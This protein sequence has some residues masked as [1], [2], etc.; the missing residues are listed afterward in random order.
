[1]VSLITRMGSVL[2]VREKTPRPVFTVFELAQRGDE[3]ALQLVDISDE[4][5]ETD[6]HGQT[7]LHVASYEG[8]FLLVKALIKRGANIEACDKN[9]YTPLHSAASNGDRTVNHL[10]V[11]S[12]LLR[13]GANPNAINNNGTSV[14]HYLVR[15]PQSDM[16]GSVLELLVER[17]CNIDVRES[18]GETPL[19]QACFRGAPETVAFLVNRGAGV[20]NLNSLGETP[21]HLA[22]RAGRS[23][24]VKTLLRFGCDP[25]IP[26]PNGTAREVAYVS[27]QSGVVDLLDEH[28]N[29]VDE[30]ESEALPDLAESTLTPRRKYSEPDIQA[31]QPSKRGVISRDFSTVFGLKYKDTIGD[32]PI[33]T[34]SRIR[35]DTQKGLLRKSKSDVTRHIR[36]DPGF[37]LELGTVSR[38]TAGDSD[39]TLEYS[40]EHDDHYFVQHFCR[41]PSDAYSS[42]VKP[43]FLREEFHHHINLVGLYNG[44]VCVVSIRCDT[45]DGN[46]RAMIRSTNG[47]KN[48]WILGTSIRSV[49]A[50]NLIVAVQ[51]RYPALTALTHQPSLALSNSMVEL[52]LLLTIQRLKFG[53]VFARRGQS[54]SEAFAND[55]ISPEYQNF[56]EFLGQEIE[57]K[58]W[59]HYRG[60]L[61]VKNNSTGET[62]YYTKWGHLEVM[63]ECAHLIPSLRRK[64]I[65]GNTVVTIVFQ[66]DGQFD[67]SSI[68]SQV[69]HAFIVVQPLK[70]DGETFYKVGVA[71]KKGVPRF[72]PTLKLPGIFRL[73]D[74]FR[75]FLFFKLINAERASYHCSAKVKGQ[76]R[77][78]VEIVQ[79]TRNGQLDFAVENAKDKP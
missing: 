64:P 6:G 45:E 62:A 23:D 39:F 2:N 1:M 5:E 17:G 61:D 14:M 28:E 37:N 43:V 13:A 57:L 30:A 76:K 56:I 50:K 34:T 75:S 11:C 18:C 59:Q 47:D 41:S 8:H 31:T 26:G 72:R 36:T 66:Q 52:D 58:G 3:K 71:S 44:A 24:L 55:S 20:D 4:L 60:D 35:R 73:D 12:T 32:H 68:L 15:Y 40:D 69:L 70:K 7:L 79:A 78:L 48:F 27:N 9:Q 46:Y 54:E 38:E 77:S 51:A 42:T 19:H 74:K 10:N 16:L 33:S 63:F 67:P 22:A 49:K 21:L 25:F 29:L 65:I 53:C